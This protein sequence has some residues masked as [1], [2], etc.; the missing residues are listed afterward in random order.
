[1]TTSA[2]VLGRAEAPLAHVFHELRAGR[3]VVVAGGP[4]QPGELVVPAES[5]TRESVAFLVRHTSGFVCVALPGADC[6][7]FRLPPM[8]PLP[9]DPVRGRYTVTVDAAVG[10]S[11]GISADDRARTIRLLGGPATTAADLVRPGHVVPCRVVE[12]GVLARPGA[13]EAASDLAGAAG[14]HPCAAYS[15]IVSTWRPGELAQGRELTEF[16]ARHGLAA[17]SVDDLRAY[18]RSVAAA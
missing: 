5:A 7:R 13:A 18:L 17:T 11:T 1:M 10:V 2:A 6:E 12:G 3:P 15:A 9:D 14:L 16:A 8:Y 4:G